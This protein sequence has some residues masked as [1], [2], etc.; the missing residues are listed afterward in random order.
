MKV[1][2]LSGN[3]AGVVKD[4]PQTEAEVAIQTGFA[5]KFEA[6]QAI[7]YET[8]PVL[9]TMQENV[10]VLSREEIA[11]VFSIPADQLGPVESSTDTPKASE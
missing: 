7:I 8:E 3:D 11:K 4:L 9:S 1:Q 10:V 5:Q 6:V 2:I